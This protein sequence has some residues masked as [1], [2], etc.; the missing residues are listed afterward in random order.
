MWKLTVPPVKGVVNPIGAGDCVTGVM[1]A[2]LV[3]GD[4]LANAFAKGLAAASAS[5][6]GMQGA[7]YRLVSLLHCVTYR[8][9]IYTSIYV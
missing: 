5:C 1:V 3:G 4:Q 9:Q 6:K 2:A 7:V 8:F